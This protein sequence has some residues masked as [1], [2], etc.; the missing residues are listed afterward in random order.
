LCRREFSELQLYLSP[1]SYLQV[2]HHI[3]AP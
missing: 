3:H 1:W 2:C